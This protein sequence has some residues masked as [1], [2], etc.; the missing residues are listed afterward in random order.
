MF[1]E[2]IKSTLSSISFNNKTKDFI[3]LNI[4]LKE[5][6]FIGFIFKDQ[7]YDLVYF[8][9][10]DRRFQDYDGISLT[11]FLEKDGETF[12]LYLEHLNG[13]KNIS[14]IFFEPSGQKIIDLSI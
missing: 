7:T 6:K 2:K 4:C 10:S 8:E 12:K 5:L 9:E 1:L 14:A 3:G 13:T 11:I